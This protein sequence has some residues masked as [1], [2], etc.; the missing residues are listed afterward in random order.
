MSGT[1]RGTV[2]DTVQGEREKE[3]GCLLVFGYLQV[4]LPSHLISSSSPSPSPSLLCVFLPS[5]SVVLL[6]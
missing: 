6:T 4:S 2:S 3:R 1:V 5:F